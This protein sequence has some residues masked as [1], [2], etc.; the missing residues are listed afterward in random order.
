MDAQNLIGTLGAIA[1]LLGAVGMI[2][3]VVQSIRRKKKSFFFVILIVALVMFVA[4]FVVTMMNPSETD[5][6]N[7]NADTPIVEE[8]KKAEQTEEIVTEAEKEEKPSEAVT[9]ALTEMVTE[10]EQKQ[11]KT[12]KKT[13]EIV[14]FTLT[15]DKVG[16]YGKLYVLNE[17]T[18]FE[19]WEIG[20]YIPTGKYNVTNLDATRGVQLSIYCGG[21]EYDGEWQYFVAD[22]NCQKPVVLMAGETG[23]LEIKEGQFVVLSDDHALQVKFEQQ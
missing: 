23:E 8:T 10:T 22:D 16:K 11:I 7:S 20:Y 1:I 21:P 9:E 4:A 3:V 18:E 19:E 12:E 2:G 6:E 5:K 14:S 17:G 13:E 15:D